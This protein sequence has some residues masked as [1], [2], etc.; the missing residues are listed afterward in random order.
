V[1]DARGAGPY[2]VDVANGHERLAKWAVREYEARI[3][4]KPNTFVSLKYV[5]ILN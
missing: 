1:Q 3:R 2:F 4:V 5:C